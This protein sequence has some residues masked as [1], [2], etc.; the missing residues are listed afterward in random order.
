MLMLKNDDLE[1]IVNSEQF[2]PWVNT[3][4]ANYKQLNNIQKGNVGEKIV[5][6][7]MLKLGHKIEAH[8]LR[9]DG[10][11]VIIDGIKTEIKFSLAQTDT[12]KRK[13]KHN[14][15]IMNHVSSGKEWERLIFLGINL[16]ETYFLKYF[17]KK[18]FNNTLKKEYFNN[19]QGGNSS[20]NDDYMCSGN[21][22]I[23]MLE[24]LKGVEEW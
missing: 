24:G 18:E 14:T 2:N 10:Y 13:I 17:T 15:F 7:I 20:N 3:P 16:D 12:S 6:A 1:S 11:D 22:L 8:S 21:K 4:F 9:T 19:Q 5:K 23:K